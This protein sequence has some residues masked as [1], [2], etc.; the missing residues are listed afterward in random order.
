MLINSLKIAFS[1][2]SKIP[3]PRTDWNKDNM[4]YAMCFFPLVGAVLGIIV[5]AFGKLSEILSLGDIFRTSIYVII[6]VIITG[7][8]H[9][10]GFLD[11]S[12]ALSSY[13]SK[14]KKL[15]ILKDPH[16]GAFAIISAAIYF[17]LQ[18]GVWSEV[19]GKT[20]FIL[21]LS[22]V[23]SRSLSALSIVTFKCAKNSGL[24]ASF[25]DAAQKEKVKYTMYFYILIVLVI[26]ILVD[27]FL[28]IS[29]FISAIVTFL[30]YKHMSMKEFGGITGDLAGYFL[31]ISELIMAITVV[32]LEKIMFI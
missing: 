1:M 21:A 29:A 31:Q 9:L 16:T 13:A 28:G 5:L 25:S 11:T 8:I 2:Y 4:K 6:P 18:F 27:K 24:A 14:E 23:L 7:G 3:M 32:V 15:E 22:F 20:L 19:K 17:V 10:D 12:D 26:M 30:Y